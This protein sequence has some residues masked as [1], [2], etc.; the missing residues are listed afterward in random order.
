MHIGPFK[1]RN[2]IALAPMAGLTDVPFRSLAWRFGVGYMVSEM[3]ASQ[4]QLWD[5]GKSSLRR[6]PVPGAFPVAVQIAG[7]EPQVMADAARRHVDSGVQVIDINFGCPAKKV[8]KKSAGSALLADS[9]QIGRI[10][11]AVARAVDVPVTV[12]TRTGL[13][14]NDDLGVVA[15][16]IAAAAGAQ[17]IVMHGRSKG[18]KF[19]G[20]IDYRNVR[21][22]KQAVSIPVLVNGDITDVASAAIALEQ[23]QADGLMIG[24][25]AIGRPWLFA[26]LAGSDVP[27]LREKWQVVLAHICAMHEFYGEEAGVRIARKHIAAYFA[28]LGVAKPTRTMQTI[29]KADE[30]ISMLRQIADRQLIDDAQNL[31]DAA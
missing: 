26:E 25:A 24:R 9:A 2:N 16:V 10:V 27:S 12:K 21:R 22:L 23:S 15:G 4:P 6:V 5:T 29:A 17:L 7:T 31:V 1:L 30:Q 14:P 28:E 3:V 11:E 19:V 8:C 13:T 18:C 20:Q